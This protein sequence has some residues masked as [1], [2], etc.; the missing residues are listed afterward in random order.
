MR[1]PHTPGH[2]HTQHTYTPVSNLLI[3]SFT[4]SILFYEII[5]SLP[6]NF[7][8]CID[9]DYNRSRQCT[10]PIVP[11]P[12]KKKKKKKKK[13]QLQLDFQHQ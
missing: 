1:T 6:L 13:T 8:N 3:Y 5:A 4:E 2:R 7:T 11:P 12:P 10:L 9:T